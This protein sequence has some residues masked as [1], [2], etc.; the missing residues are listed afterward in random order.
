MPK[1]ATVRLNVSFNYQFNGHG[2][3][4]PRGGCLRP[5]L[6]I[7][8]GECPKVGRQSTGSRTDPAP[9]KKTKFS[10]TFEVLLEIFGLSGKKNAQNCMSDQ[11]ICLSDQSAL[12]S[13]SIALNNDKI[14]KT[15][16]K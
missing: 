9:P 1:T 16:R 12:T 11:L 10:L 14:L 2:R 15:L 4:N 6:T 13:F 8:G 3:P 7:G 5:L